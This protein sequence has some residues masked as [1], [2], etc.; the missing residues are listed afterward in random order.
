MLK[1]VNLR[2]K[3]DLIHDHWR[4]RIVAEFNETQVKIS[5]VKG[6]FDWHHHE[7]EDELFWVLSGRLLIQFRDQDVWL[8]EGELLVVPKGVEHR[9]VAPDEVEVAVIEPAG[10]VNTGNLTNEK[11]RADLE[12]I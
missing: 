11:T 9:P 7:H 6:E 3:L 5:K 8:E 2:N 10:T 1:K 12:W 4:Q